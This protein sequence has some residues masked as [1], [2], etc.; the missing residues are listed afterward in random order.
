M[1][2]EQVLR[3]RLSV[4]RLT[5]PGVSTA[6]DVVRRLTCVQSQEY[7]HGFWSLG[8]RAAGLGYDDVQRE[9]DAGAFVR[10]HV[11]RPT[12]HFVAAEDLR[13]ILRATSPRVQQINRSRYRQ[14]GL[15]QSVLDRSADVLCSALR[16]IDLTRTQLG[17]ALVADGIDVAGQRLAYLVMN[18]ELEGLICSGPMRGAQHTY[19]V[20]A[21][22]VSPTPEVSTEEGLAELAR[23]FFAGHGPAGVKDLSRWSSL[24]TASAHLGLELARDRLEQVAVEGQALWWDP[25]F[26][27]PEPS[28]G[29]TSTGETSPGD[30]PVAL[31]LPLYDEA[32][33]SYPQ[34]NFPLAPGHPHPPGTDL[35]VGSV[36][37]DA[38][39]VGTWRRTVRGRTVQVETRLAGGVS[40]AGR[41]AV[42]EAVAA[43]A[44][45][46]DK[47]LEA[48]GPAW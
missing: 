5:A 3:R 39:N 17:H 40:A 20:V 36:I 2:R 33:L 19:A 30:P 26:A 22:R 27:E 28:T 15:D 42:A 45:F 7:A 29:D 11:L 10:T 32:T 48:P 14:L 21:E 37:L 34:L 4:Q 8:M 18:A 38:V 43:L 13:W 25:S 24:T 12:W 46:L 44:S 41:S 23:R 1:S 16:G 6:V 47:Q 9:F 31:L 35:F